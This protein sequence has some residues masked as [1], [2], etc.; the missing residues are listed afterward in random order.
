M[1]PITTVTDRGQTSIPADLRK[2]F[3]LEKGQKLSWEPYSDKAIIIHI[4]S[5]EP[6]ERGAHVVRGICKHRFR[7]MDTDQYMA[8]IRE[9]EQ[10]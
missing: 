6:K 5:S 1:N 8:F 4:T 10:D 9:G 2:K 3:K 7:E